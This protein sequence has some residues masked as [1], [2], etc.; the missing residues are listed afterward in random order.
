VGTEEKGRSQ[1]ILEIVQKESRQDFLMDLQ[2]DCKRKRRINID[3]KVGH[4][5]E[6][7]C[8]L[9]ICRV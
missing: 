3:S 8:Y 7:N 2:V 9:V 4:L 6:W 5:L 1:W